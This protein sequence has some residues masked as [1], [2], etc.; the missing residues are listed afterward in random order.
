MTYEVGSTPD[1]EVHLRITANT[2]TGAISANWVAL[3]AIRDVLKGV[4]PGELTS[5]HLHPLYAGKSVNTP[6][7][8][9][10][11]LMSEGLVRPSTS[12]RRCYE[13]ADAATFDAAVNAWR[14]VG[15][16]KTTG[17]ASAR[18]KVKKSASTKAAQPTEASKAVLPEAVESGAPNATQGVPPETVKD[19][20]PSPLRK[21]ST[22]ARNSAPRKVAAKRRR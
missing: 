10:A 9:L 14:N 20:P 1:A 11:A 8:L 18:G 16:E 5:S 22:K 21:G 6:G 3:R 13:C 7:F 17:G 12:K 2:G 15:A 4:A 19:A